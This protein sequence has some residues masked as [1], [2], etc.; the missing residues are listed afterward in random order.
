MSV[1]WNPPL[2]S[3]NPVA[4]CLPL[5]SAGWG[6][7]CPTSYRKGGNVGRP[8]L[9]PPCPLPATAN[10]PCN[11][12]PLTPQTKASPCQREVP[13]CEAEGFLPVRGCDSAQGIARQNPSGRL[14]R[15]P[16]P[17]WRYAPP[18]PGT[19]ESVFD[20]GGF[21]APT[22][23]FTSNST[24]AKSGKVCYNLIAYRFSGKYSRNPN[25]KKGES[26]LM[27]ERLWGILVDSFGKNIAARPDRHHPADRH[28]VHA[29]A[30]HRGGGGAGAVCPCARFAAAGPVLYLGHPRHARAGAAVRCVLRPARRRHPD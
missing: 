2:R 27:S 1:I 13:A 4:F 21:S 16:A 3:A 5:T 12:P 19:G 18:P 28:L 7:P 17:F 23:N 9:W 29:G 14:R 15:P 30:Y 25:Q 20:K 26:R 11:P 10:L 8:A 22:L 24:L 6:H